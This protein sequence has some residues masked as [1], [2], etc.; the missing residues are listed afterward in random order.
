[1]ASYLQTLGVKK[2]D[3]VLLIL[4]RRIEWW[5]TMIAL[6]KI[7]A[8]VIPGSYLLTD[9]DIVYRV[10]EADISTIITCEDEMI[11]NHVEKACQQLSERKIQRVCAFE[12]LQGKDGWLSYWDGVNNAAPFV[13]PENVNTNNDSML[14]YF[15]SGTTGEPKGVVHNFAYPLSHI[16]TGKYWLKLHENSLHLTLS[17]TGWAMAIWGSFYSQFICGAVVCIYDFDGH[18]DPAQLMTYMQDHKITSFFAPP[19]IYRFMLH[20]GLEKY[21]LSSLEYCT[22]AGEA[23]FP[24]IFEE[25][26][27][28]TGIKLMECFGQTETP[29]AVGSYVWCTPKPGA[30]GLP[31][32]QLPI[33][34]VDEHGNS[35]PPNVRGHLVVDLRK[36]MPLGLFKEYFNN[37]ELTS[38]THD[39]D[40]YYTGDM[41]TRDEDGY[42]WY[43]SRADDVIKSS[44]YRI[45]PFEVESVI[46]T[47]PAVAECAVTGVPDEIRGQL[48]KATIV[49]KPEYKEKADDALVK[50]IQLYVKSQTA[51]YKYP[52]VIEF[53]DV[54]PKTITGK[55]R[56]VEIREKDAAKA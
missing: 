16:L 33:D 40:Y 50:E 14:M 39:H 49:L 29:L 51:P 9:R 31:N 21:D 3:R 17:D 23:L 26:K 5:Y 35:C 54:L 44:G 55:I 38:K 4:K 28:L 19:T 7:G 52:R 13:R 36:G 27:R 25:W 18:F 12:Q 46:M 6:H 2:G 1:V 48:V 11:M 47:H 22:T 56:R 15:T 20:E 8:I 10:K 37:K 24:K 53:V 43:M 41:V 34:V 42:L 30:M 32:P 45:G